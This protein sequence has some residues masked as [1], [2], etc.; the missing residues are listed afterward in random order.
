MAVPLAFPV[1]PFGDLGGNETAE[2]IVNILKEKGIKGSQISSQSY[3]GIYIRESVSEKV[4]QNMGLP[5]ESHV[6]WDAMHRAG[7]SDYH[8]L[9][10]NTFVDNV[11]TTV[12]DVQNESN[13]VQYYAIC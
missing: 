13:P 12:Q 9:K 8:V 4:A 5:A 6:N 11:K 2:R 3:N 1:V 7:R 10:D